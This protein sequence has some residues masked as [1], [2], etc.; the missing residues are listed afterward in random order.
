[1]LKNESPETIFW[2][3]YA[4]KVGETVLMLVTHL[5]C[6]FTPS[7]MAYKITVEYGPSSLGLEEEKLKAYAAVSGFGLLQMAPKVPIL[8]VSSHHLCNR[9]I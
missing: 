5:L 2:P 8:T 7:Q 1:M 4:D 3:I 6:L 9:L